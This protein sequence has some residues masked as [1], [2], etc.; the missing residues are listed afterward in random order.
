MFRTMLSAVLAL[1]CL[2]L[3]SQ[4]PA[5]EPK[6]SLAKSVVVSVRVPPPDS[7]PVAPAPTAPALHAR[8]LP[9]PA[10]ATDVE[11]RKI[12]QQIKFRSV[13]KAPD[14]AEYFT[15]ALSEQGWTTAG[16][17][18]VSGHSAVLRRTRAGATV[19]VFIQT[20]GG[21][22]KVSVQTRQLDWSNRPLATVDSGAQTR[23]VESLRV[24][25]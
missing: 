22:S 19:M 24:D 15:S 2:S 7:E 18:R 21:W 1:W 17:D 12:V 3:A 9:L 5:A 16:A 25:R 8:E 20:T 10:D 23:P 11:Y 6:P 4:S 13:S 14:L